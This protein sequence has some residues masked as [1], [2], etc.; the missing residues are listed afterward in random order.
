MKKMLLLIALICFLSFVHSEELKEITCSGSGNN[1]SGVF[2][3]N[4][5]CDIPLAQGYLNESKIRVEFEEND[6]QSQDEF[7]FD[8]RVYLMV[9]GT[10][11]FG[12]DK[13]QL[14]CSSIPFKE[15]LSI[16]PADFHPWFSLSDEV[17]P[18]SKN[19]ADDL[20][21]L[22][23]KRPSKNQVSFKPESN[24][25]VKIVNDLITKYFVAK[26]KY[27]GKALS[28]NP[29]YDFFVIVDETPKKI[30]PEE[31]IPGT[32]IKLTLE[33]LKSEAKKA[34]FKLIDSKDQ[35]APCLIESV[36]GK[37][38]GFVSCEW[39]LIKISWKSSTGLPEEDESG[40]L[41]L[42][43]N[44]EFKPEDSKV[45]EET[46]SCEEGA[47]RDCTTS[48]NCSGIQTCE[49]KKWSSCVDVP[50]DNCP[51]GNGNGSGEQEIELND[52]VLI[53][54]YG[55]IF[56]LG[57]GQVKG[58]ESRDFFQEYCELNPNIDRCKIVLGGTK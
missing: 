20:V 51:A 42:Y 28:G 44:L 54:Y 5:Y 30:G 50:G 13:I 47:T 1:Y 27:L 14:D 52:S 31:M 34:E 18:Y 38:P 22:N 46:P 4:S 2:A 55:D 21:E 24:I 48:E 7:S 29:S 35:T 26:F 39:G 16:S 12:K 17:I 49:N 36:L 10:D 8:I 32:K 45:V 3:S 19:C 15:T 25:Q 33:S 23:I 40:K 6:Y 57:K 56:G 41:K 43:F 37:E 58:F 53:Y 9:S 11:L